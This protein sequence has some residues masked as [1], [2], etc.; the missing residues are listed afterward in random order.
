MN[1][2]KTVLVEPIGE[3]K[4][5][6]NNRSRYMRLRVNSNGQAQVTMPVLSSEKNAI[7]FVKSKLEWIHQQQKKMKAGLTLFTPESN[8]QTKF[9]KLKLVITPHAKLTNHI[10]NGILQVNIPSKFD[11]QQPEIQQFIKNIIIKL[12]HHEAKIY[13]PKRLSELAAMHNFSFQKVF[14]KHVKTRWG[15]CSSVNNINLNIHLMRLPDHL[16]DYV[17]LHELT[18]TRVK[19]HSKTFWEELEKSCPGAKS[20]NKELK[21][22]Q[23]DLF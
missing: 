7:Q 15:S 11:I 4:L 19:N 3:V 21:N 10:G 16:I 5:V 20:F 8:F 18:H 13:L 14:V 6:K 17:L 2:E 22:Y 1:A 9:H 12:L 23:A